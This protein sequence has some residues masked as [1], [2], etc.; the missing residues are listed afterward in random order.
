MSTISQPSIKQSTRTCR[1]GAARVVPQQTAC[2]PTSNSQ[3]LE[4]A[5]KAAARIS[6]QQ[7]KQQ[8]KQQ[9]SCKPA[10]RIHRLKT[11]AKLILLQKVQ[12]RTWLYDLLPAAVRFIIPVIFLAL[13]AMPEVAA[14]RHLWTYHTPLDPSWNGEYT[15]TPVEGGSDINP[16]EPWVPV[17]PQ[18]GDILHITNNVT[19]YLP[20]NVNLANLTIIIES[21]GLDLR[22]HTLTTITELRQDPAGQ[23]TLRIGRAGYYPAIATDNFT[24][25]TGAT[26]EYYNFDGAL[27]A[28]PSTYSNLLL[29]NT[30]GGAH[31]MILAANL[32]VTGNLTLQNTAG[33]GS[34]NLTIGNSAAARTLT[35]GNITVGNHTR[36]Q[37][38]TFNAI[39]NIRVNGNL[40]NNGSISL[41]NQ[42]TRYR[43]STNGA[44]ELTFAGAGNN[45]FDGNGSELRL[46]RLIIDKGTGQNAV[47]DANPRNLELWYRTDLGN[48]GA[49]PNP[50]IN[51]ALWIRNGTLRLGDNI[52]IEKLADRDEQNSGSDF[53]IPLNGCLW[54]D[55]AV[56]N[57]TTDSGNAGNTGVTV[58]GQLRI[59]AGELNT[60][61]SAGIVFRESAIIR[62]EGGTT[63]ISQFRRSN[64]AGVHLASFNMSGGVLNVNGQGETNASHARFSLPLSTQSF[65][66]SGG[67]INLSNPSGAGILALGPD[68][69]NQNVSGG[70]ININMSGAGNIASTVPL[71]NLNLQGGTLAVADIESIGLQPLVINNNLV[72]GAGTTLTMNDQDL[73][74]AGNLTIGSG[75][76]YNH[77]ANT[78]RFFRYGAVNNNGTT[79]TNNG[80]PTLGFNNVTLA[81]A[82]NAGYNT[83]KTVYFP[84]GGTPS[85][86]IA[87]SFNFDS[88]WQTLDLNNSQVRV[89][90]DINV[91]QASRIIN[92]PV[93]GILLQ[94]VETA[95]QSLR[96]QRL[97]SANNFEVNNTANVRLL[98]HSHMEAITLTNGSLYIGNRRL[99]LNQPVAG[100]SYTADKMISTNGSS[101][102][103]RY[104]YS[105]SSTG[106]WLYPVG[107]GAAPLQGGEEEL[108][109]T[110]NF[111]RNVF[112]TT[113]LWTR[114]S[115]A[116]PTWV[117]DNQQ[118]L[119]NGQANNQWARMITP[120]IDLSGV[121]NA[122]LTFD[123]RRQGDGGGA[124][125][126]WDELYV[127]Y[128]NGSS[129]VVIGS[130][131]AEQA[132]F[133][134][135]TITLPQASF[136]DQYRIAFR[137]VAS[138]RNATYTRVDNVNISNLVESDDKKYTPMTLVIAGG[139]SFS[140]SNNFF[141]V[142][143]VNRP[144]PQA[145]PAPQFADQI[146]QYYWKTTFTGSY[147][148]LTFDYRFDFYYQDRIMSGGSHRAW[149]LVSNQWQEGGDYN[150]TNSPTDPRGRVRF[151][152]ALAF[153]LVTGEFTAGNQ[154]A[155]AAGSGLETYY[156]RTVEG[157]WETP[158][159][160]SLTSHTGAA[161]TTTPGVNDK[162]VIASG[163]T[164]NITAIN[165]RASLVLINQGGTLNV[166][167]FT[168]HE[169][170]ELRGDGTLRL[171]T[172][173]LPTVT[174]DNLQEFTETDNSTIEFYGTTD[175]TL[176]VLSTYNNLRITGTGIKTFADRNLNIRDSLLISQ[177]TAIISNSTN[178]N[179]TIEGT[180][181]LQNG[182][183]LT[184]PATT[185]QRTITAAAI[186]IDNATMS[187]AAGAGTTHE[188]ILRGGGITMNGAAAAANLHTATNN[189]NLTLQGPGS[190]ALAGSHG[191][192]LHLNRLIIDKDNLFDEVSTTANLILGGPTNGATKALELSTGTLIIER[193]QGAMATDITLSSGGASFDIPSTAAMIVRGGDAS[194]RN[195]I[196]TTGSTGVRL[197]GL[198]SLGNTARALF[199]GGNNDLVYSASG[200]AAIRVNGEATLNVGGQLRRSTTEP[201]AILSYTQTG[202]TVAIG[203]QG[204]TTDTRGVF[205]VL[206]PGSSFTHTGGSLTI[207]RSSGNTGATPGDVILQPQ[208]ADI[209]GNAIL[210]IN[211]GALAQTVS[212]NSQVPLNHLTIDGG[213]TTVQPVAR[214]LTLLGNLTIATD[215]V[216]T[217]NNYSLSIGGNFQNNGTFT[218]LSDTT[219]FEGGVQTLSG[220]GTNTFHHLVSEPATSLTLQRDI[221]I[222]GNLAIG[223]GEF[224]DGGHTVL[225]QG[226]ISNTGIHNSGPDGQIILGGGTA[227]QDISGGGIFGNLVLNN[228][229]NARL[230]GNM[231]LSG[232]LTLSVGLLNIR[233]HRLT[234]S[235]GSQV[236]PPAGGFSAS[237][238]IQTNG[239]M[240]DAGIRKHFG[241]G[242]TGNITFPTGVPGKYTPA[243]MD[244]SSPVGG[245]TMDV[246]PVN[247]VHPTISAENHNR[248]LQ[249]YWG[250]TTSGI[251]NAAGTMVFH[252]HPVDLRGDT[253]NYYAA[254]LR[255]IDDT[256]AKT[257]MPYIDK[258][259]DRITFNVTGD[260]PGGSFLCGED[261]AIPSVIWVYSTVRS[262]DWDEP[263]VWNTG[264]VPPQGVIVVIQ[265]PHTVSI[266][267]NR[268]RTYRTRINGRL[269]I[270]PL[271]TAHNFGLVEGTGTL[272]LQ[273]GNLPS[274]KWSDIF[275]SCNGGT[276]E[277]GGPNSYTLD[278]RTIYN[279]Y[280]NLILTGSGTKTLPNFD[281]TMC[282]DLRIEESVILETISNRSINLN[283]NM[284]KSE[285]SRYLA[286][287]TG[288]SLRLNSLNNQDI[289]GSFPNVNDRF[290]N[291]Y[292]TNNKRV[293]LNGPVSIR[294]F[295]GLS[296]GSILISS[297]TNLITLDR[298]NTG[299]H[300]GLL[301]I[302][303]F[304]DGPLKSNITHGHLLFNFPIGNEGKKKNTNLININHTSGSKYWQAEYLNSNPASEGKFSNQFIEELAYVSAVEYWVI[305]GPVN[306]TA[307]ISLS[308]TGTSEI[309]A[310][311][312]ND[313]LDKLRI[314]EW[315]E[316]EENWEISGNGAVAT[317]P[318]INGSIITADPVSFEGT[319]KYFTL[320]SVEALSIP[321]ASISSDSQSICE[322]ETYIME[323]TL[324][325]DSP[326]EIRYS[327]G[328]TTS[329]WIHI[330]SSPHTIP[331]STSNTTSYTLSAVRSVSG[332]PVNGVVF[333]SPVTI[334]V[335]PL[336]EVFSVGGGG[337]ICGIQTAEITLDGSRLGF[338]YQLFRDPDIFVIDRSGTGSPLSFSQV[339]IAG[340][341]RIS[342]FSTGN[343]QC[344]KEMMGEALVNIIEGASAEI[345]GLLTD[346]IICEGE[347]VTISLEITSSGPF[348][349]TI[350]EASPTG[351]RFFN[352][353]HASLQHIGGYTYYFSLAEPPLWA[354]QGNPTPGIAEFTYI[355]VGFSDTSGCQTT[356]EGES[357]VTV[358]KIP[359]T[360]PQY[361]IPNTFEY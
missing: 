361:H 278:T 125:R 288:Q 241:T 340:T 283:G 88:P 104:R 89:Q 40:T 204:A 354:N 84:S 342:A 292:I 358:Y 122:T 92:D 315:N 256:W 348:E 133:T 24:T 34:L 48:G 166:N 196:R 105:G 265:E 270:S 69:A 61:K 335:I 239:D 31:N 145:N 119:F 338:T 349:L 183:T 263:E 139:G 244:F 29:S 164:I 33:S 102:E 171:A 101:G 320:G 66:M 79:I 213:S 279:H 322:G 344:S 176:P 226:H 293:T 306:G 184:I 4:A 51:K 162:V 120:P 334:T 85:V 56:V 26:V 217:S 191:N 220:S 172:P 58:I 47:L 167:T 267:T 50:I 180:L 277:F 132:S 235:E 227:R 147:T 159:S 121:S 242:E 188:I 7:G 68:P 324:T 289:T 253:T 250:I 254:Q 238:M 179:L 100:G 219:L 325:G 42:P 158:A 90:G 286:E 316:I 236:V 310:A 57:V 360:G 230:L 215:A 295:L 124:T 2:K 75:A 202:G 274:G 136:T 257:E 118:A 13:T 350:A 80:A 150:A 83:A 71:F 10:S 170:E 81:K 189:V 285:N 255:L 209:S 5:A 203:T 45:I 282:G 193:T 221:T 148:N 337:N 312:G 264:A 205:E 38:G 72:L 301:H 359:E 23:G 152:P 290:N 199:D 261:D 35:A 137:A 93:R 98:E 280:N 206:N 12:V 70:T 329:G 192:T 275:L 94:P 95:S 19:V 18:A 178:G 110:E 97:S 228:D 16:V 305:E 321:T 78:T 144:H 17:Y 25:A 331:V 128:W 328:T 212:I 281:I 146:I 53:F 248:V 214:R 296:N 64:S 276:V 1:Q 269:E 339:S 6:N 181:N 201:G 8:G 249:Y 307:K 49:D 151:P 195:T 200:N 223:G 317:G 327:D 123:E 20:G 197:D 243:V 82:D 173:V 323:I 308:L 14:Q 252:Y 99:T 149:R 210:N 303:S 131:T 106:T 113:P 336:P 353:T 21:G 332:E 62:I 186:T 112:T 37:T 218:S 32:T 351:T 251:S 225:V 155:F 247:N 86:N 28:T 157:N 9:T 216:Y 258:N 345:T 3:H 30:D 41:T 333:G 142:I 352:L 240:G 319:P 232:N 96:I 36:L 287:F 273:A 233:N 291:L 87:G 198:L 190:T 330:D 116:T 314:V 103:L 111:S 194:L 140:G 208:T 260:N 182:A 318:I 156:S 44:A 63:T 126:R 284:L 268:K 304:I 135:R 114:E 11:N 60:R 298:N 107:S 109:W 130:Y 174:M 346:D 224:N 294:T 154:N 160:W 134:T 55:G 272:A 108:D 138:S 46:Y 299:I 67:T 222:T 76:T 355:I 266:T 65:I 153:G 15:W 313:N 39:H 59:T 211:T 207:S 73:W 246:Y 169:F 175:Y 343:P 237:A 300:S 297:R 309:A 43:A 341:Y 177:S 231:T 27:N 91:N 229:K 165:K 347:S 117:H 129:W 54:I 168:G 22:T 161:A 77:G 187:A 127:E 262:G 185:N 245:G 357:T 259:N 271:T 74:L 234:L 302:N 311:L 115:S 326:W 143:P 356:F 141:G 163:H 52:T